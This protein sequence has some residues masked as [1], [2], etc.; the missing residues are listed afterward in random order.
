MNK[1]LILHRCD[2]ESEFRYGIINFLRDYF[3]F[4]FS[5]CWFNYKLQL[6]NQ[7][8]PWKSLAICKGQKFISVTLICKWKNHV[9]VF[10]LTALYYHP[11]RANATSERGNL[12]LLINIFTLLCITTFNIIWYFIRYCYVD[13]RVGICKNKNI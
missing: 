1:E 2:S 9:W 3:I 10:I 12:H 8:R 6:H 13:A 11:V 4:G 7:V 5:N